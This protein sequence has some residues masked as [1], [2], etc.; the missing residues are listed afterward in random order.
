MRRNEVIDLRNYRAEDNADADPNDPGL[1]ELPTGTTLLHGQYKITG[2]LNSGGFAITYNATDSLNRPVVI[3]ECFPNIMCSRNG[4][5]VAP[6]VPGYAEELTDLIEQFEK[7][8]HSLAALKHP[9]IVHVHQVFRENDTAYMAIDFIDGPDL[10]DVIENSPKRIAPE[11]II[12]LTHSMLHAIKYIHDEG[13]LHRDISPDN[14][15]IDTRSEPVLIDFGAARKAVTT[16]NR[17]ISRMKFVKDGYSPQE[18]YL[19]GAEQGAFSDLYSFAAS[20]YHAIAG[21]PPVDGQRRLSAL[22]QKKPD[23]YEKLAG[24]IKGYPGGFL[25]AI[26]AALSVSPAKR[27]QSADDWLARLPAYRKRV[28]VADRV[29]TA[30]Q[31]TATNTLNVASAITSPVPTANELEPQGELAA[32]KRQVRGGR[33]RMLTMLGVAA[34][35]ALVGGYW[36][37][38]G[39]FS[40]QSSGAAPQVD[41]QPVAQSELPTLSV[42]AIDSAISINGIGGPDS[43]I[44]LTVEPNELSNI[45]A[46]ALPQSIFDRKPPVQVSSTTANGAPTNFSTVDP[47]LSADKRPAPRPVLD[48]ALYLPNV[49]P[50]ITLPFVA[51]ASFSFAHAAAIDDGIKLPIGSG[52]SGTPEPSQAF[53]LKP[54]QNAVFD[55]TPPPPPSPAKPGPVSAT[56]IAAS[57]WDVRMPFEE[58]LIQVRNA[59]TAQISE[60]SQNADL[61]ISGDWIAQ[62]VVIYSL[63]DKALEPN[64][65]ISS[66]LLNDLTIDPDGYTRATVRYRDPVSGQIDRGLIAVPVYSDIVLS[67]QTRLVSE[68][69][70]SAWQVRVVASEATNGFQTGDV[71]VQEVLSGTE[72]QT[73]DDLEKAF[74]A[75]IAAGLETAEFNVFRA[76]ALERIAVPLSRAIAE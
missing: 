58:T 16:S 70:D 61:S 10:L 24:Q 76:G 19:E 14:I 49:A 56:Q 7:E 17:V 47:V 69:K 3:K 65:P 31:S 45:A 5:A 48:L 72:I 50:N 9:N 25:E 22:A 54:E 29:K 15:M 33:R 6:R 28:S 18:F 71:V 60:L 53:D 13:M 20:M 4:K 27:P 68:V 34:A 46:L 64:T 44:N 63:N 51:E 1:V 62:N 35:I 37:Y 41:T 57:H 21:V 73:H 36:A 55:T 12:R 38:T 30:I 39:P 40:A 52:F 26:D 75:V 43:P 8:A 32:Y 67:D 2:F 74:I 42:A 66:H 11:E 59:H 23:P